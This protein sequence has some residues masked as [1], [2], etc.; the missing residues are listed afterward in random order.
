MPLSVRNTLTRI[1][2]A[3]IQLLQLGRTPI[4]GVIRKIGDFLTNRKF[5]ETVLELG[6]SYF[7]KTKACLDILSPS[8]LKY[9]ELWHNYLLITI[10]NNVKDN[11]ITEPVLNAPA[12]EPQSIFVLEKNPRIQLHKAI[13]PDKLVRTYNIPLNSVRLTMN[14]L[15]TTTLNQDPNF[16]IFDAA[17]MNTCQSFVESMLNSNNLTQNIVDE[18]TLLALKPQNTTALVAALGSYSKVSKMIT[19]GAGIVD[20][21]IH[22]YKIIWA[23]RNV[24][25]T[26]T[27]CINID[28]PEASIMPQD[29]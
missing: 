24:I 13:D 19:D 10:A 6:V 14:S 21:L 5:S 11:T 18:A 8:L 2:D 15:M 17:N 7:K 1:G 25:Q 16:F 28:S 9:D 20:K 22:D 23:P 12:T 3:D 27:K 29:D 26:F 4:P